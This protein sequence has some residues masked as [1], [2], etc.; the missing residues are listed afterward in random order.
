VGGRASPAGV[1][2]KGVGGEFLRRGFEQGAAGDRFMLATIPLA[3]V[4]AL[5]NVEPVL[6][7]MG[8]RPY[9]EP[10]PAPLLTIPAP[11]D[12]RPNPPPVELRKQ[13]ATGALLPIAGE[14][15]A[16]SLGLPRHGF[17]VFVD[18]AIPARNP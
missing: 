10:D 6:E 11:V 15:G 8:E 9:P 1:P 17:R 7:Q 16:A 5:A 4:S 12:L 14:I 3:P 2:V 13:S 18:P